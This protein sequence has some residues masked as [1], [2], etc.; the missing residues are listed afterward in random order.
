MT[1]ARCT[2]FRFEKIEVNAGTGCSIDFTNSMMYME[3]STLCCVFQW[4][5]II[6]ENLPF[7]SKHPIIY[8]SV[9]SYCLLR[10]QRACFPTARTYFTSREQLLFWRLS[11]SL[12]KSQLVP[13][14][15]FERAT[16]F[17]GFLLTVIFCRKCI[18]FDFCCR[19]SSSFVVERIFL[20]CYRGQE[21]GGKRNF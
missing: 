12:V 11:E 6:T 19:F 16:S 3:V 9:E 17:H 8:L 10:C 21:Q 7:F 15:G 20:I 1:D 18:A 13:L 5:S 4:P 14:I 2:V